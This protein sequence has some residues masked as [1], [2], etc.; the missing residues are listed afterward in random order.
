MTNPPKKLSAE[1]QGLVHD[2]RDVVEQAKVL[3]LT[4]NHGNLLQDFIWESQNIDAASAS[5]PNAPVSKETAK[6][7]GNQALGGLRTLG[8]LIVS[9]GQFRKLCKLKTRPPTFVSYLLTTCIVNDATILLRDMAGD[10]AQKAAEKVNPSQDALEQIDRPADDNTWHDV[11]D[12]SKDNIKNQLKDT[13]DKNAP[14]KSKDLKDAAGDA[15]EEAHPGGSRDPKDAAR[16][17]ANDQRS[18]GSSGIDAVSGLAS[19]AQTLKDRAS[20]NIPDEHKDKARE[21]KETGKKQAKNYLSKKMPEERREQTIWRLKKM[22]V[23][24][25]GHPD[26]KLP[27]HKLLHNFDTNDKL[28]T[29]KPLLLS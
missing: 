9:N 3:L 19:G 7:H 21:L 1:G 26:C 8:T 10:A 29:A 28:Q 22:L 23:E 2:L 24:I 12:L 5:T 4:K 25:Q 18:G 14:V 6:Q 13:Y 27:F 16:I 17:A 20:Q 11:P 15:T